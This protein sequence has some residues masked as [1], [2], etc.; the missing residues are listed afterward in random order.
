MIRIKSLFN[1]I[2]D[3]ENPYSTVS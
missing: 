1:T 2:W 3:H